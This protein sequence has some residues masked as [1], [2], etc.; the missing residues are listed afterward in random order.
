MEVQRKEPEPD[1]Q[2]DDLPLSA[3]IRSGSSSTGTG[4]AASEPQVDQRNV[5]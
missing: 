2:L 3:R 5:R 4:I 1:S